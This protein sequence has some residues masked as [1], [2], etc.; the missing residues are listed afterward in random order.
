MMDRIFGNAGMVVAWL[1]TNA[2]NND[3][4]LKF[5]AVLKDYGVSS[6]QFKIHAH[7]LLWYD[8]PLDCEIP[9][10]YFGDRDAATAAKNVVKD[11]LDRPYW[12]RMWVVQEV[13][14]AKNLVLKYGNCQVSWDDFVFWV[15]TILY[16]SWRRFRGFKTCTVAIAQSDILQTDLQRK[17]HMKGEPVSLDT[18]PKYY[19]H[20]ACADPRDRII[21]L[22]GITTRFLDMKDR[23]DNANLYEMSERRLCEHVARRYD[24]KYEELVSE[25]PWHIAKTLTSQIGGQWR[26]TKLFSSEEELLAERRTY[27][28]TPHLSPAI[29]FPM[30]LLTS[31]GLES[32]PSNECGVRDHGSW[33]SST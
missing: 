32:K 28:G 19:R 21:S 22:L 4:L 25:R 10:D 5:P 11:L 24:C 15:R 18:W 12:T 3:K 16:W 33:T 26:M 27:Y 17:Y 30:L 29:R 8:R 2:T 13:V 9:V 6:I 14:L 23:L 31:V 20:R 7:L 1:G